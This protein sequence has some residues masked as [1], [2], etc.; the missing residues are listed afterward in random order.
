MIKQLQAS[1][2]LTPTN[3]EIIENISTD[4]GRLLLVSLVTDLRQNKG[5]AEWN[6]NAM[7]FHKV[8]KRQLTPTKKKR[9]RER[10]WKAENSA[11]LICNLM[12]I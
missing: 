6:V 9:E 3:Q 2:G 8:E 5:V 12:G 7:Y 10:R 11:L 1:R 4:N